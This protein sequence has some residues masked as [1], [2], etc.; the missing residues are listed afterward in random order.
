MAMKLDKQILKKLHN[1][2]EFFK[3]ARHIEETNLCM[4]TLP[5]RYKDKKLKITVE[6]MTYK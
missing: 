1:K 3:I 6:L 5:C 4:V 2:E